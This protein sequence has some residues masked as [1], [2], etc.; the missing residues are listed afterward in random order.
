MGA[1]DPAARK[2]R[3]ACLRQLDAVKCQRV[4]GR[5]AILLDVQEA[6]VWHLAAAEDFGRSVD[7]NVVELS[8]ATGGRRKGLR[9]LH[10]LPVKCFD[11]FETISVSGGACK[12]SGDL[13]PTIVQCLTLGIKAGLA[14][15]KSVQFPVGEIERQSW[16]LKCLLHS[17]RGF[18]RPGVAAKVCDEVR[19][20]RKTT[21][22]GKESEHM[23]HMLQF[24]DFR[25]SEVSL[26]DGTVHDGSR[27]VIPYPAMAWA[28]HSEQAYRWQKPH[29]INVLE[30]IVFLKLFACMCVCV[31]WTIILVGYCMCWT[32]G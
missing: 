14:K 10:N 32:V 1:K 19:K 17:T 30:L 16:V 5:L 15:W 2:V 6:G 7:A 11:V 31:M 27:Q 3:N 8:T 21:V 24:G 25:G 9:L 22:A 28:W 12:D 23:L 13:E 4:D 29:H 26:R 20:L 18:S